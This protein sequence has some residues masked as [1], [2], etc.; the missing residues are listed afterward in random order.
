MKNAI[1]HLKRKNRR[2]LLLKKL[3]ETLNDLSLDS[4]LPQDENDKICIQVFE[5][6]NGIAKDTEFGTDVREKNIELSIEYI[7]GLY[8]TNALT[9][10]IPFLMFFREQEVELVQINIDDIFQN[11]K[12]LMRENGF[13]NGNGDFVI[14]N[15][16][17]KKCLSIEITEYCTEVFSW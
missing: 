1:K 13:Q 2:N 7:N 10:K 14:I 15:K 3:S 4:F 17:M 12:V 8:E 16:D 5:Q 6:L 9:F 11:L